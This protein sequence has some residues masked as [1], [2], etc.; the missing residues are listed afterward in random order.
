MTARAIPP[1][2][3]I[4][5][6]NF[7]N[8][9]FHIILWTAMVTL[10]RL[11]RHNRDECRMDKL[12]ELNRADDDR[13]V[14][15]LEPLIERAP[16]IAT[17]VAGHRPFRSADDLRRAIRGEL[18][19]L[20]EAAR[21]RLFRAHPELAPENP[22]V[23]T[24]AS[25]SEQGRLQL[26][27]GRNKYR[28]RLDD[29]NARYRAKFGFPFITALVRHAD[30]E[31]V[32]AEFEARLASDRRSEIERT[33]DQISAVSAARVSAAFGDEDAEET[34]GAAAET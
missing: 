29:L 21:L 27:R 25:Q 16:E 7:K 6:S 5:Y 31:S 10:P 28:A 13:A 24:G 19:N 18:V 1:L 14:S 22:L 26:T 34:R 32:L 11:L 4:G 23:M 8:I 20:D 9:R 33:I 12:N 15:L 3:G 17:R 2:P 30:M